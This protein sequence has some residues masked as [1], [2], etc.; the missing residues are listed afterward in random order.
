MLAPPLDFVQH[1][2][3]PQLAKIGPQVEVQLNHYGF[4]PAGKGE[5]TARINRRGA[6]RGLDLIDRDK[7]RSRKVVAIVAAL[8]TSIA[9]RE[10]HRVVRKLNWD[11][12]QTEVVDVQDPV[13]P[14]NVLM[15]ELEYENVT[16]V[17]S[18]FGS[19]NVPAERVADAIVRDIRR[20]VRSEVPVG[21]NLAD[22]LILPMAIAAHFEDANGSFR[23]GKLTQHSITHAE[24]IQKF[25]EVEVRCD[26]VGSEDGECIVSIS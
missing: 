2:Y 3:L 10:I 21:P 4:Y 17:F 18:S 20:Y 5:F 19:V 12:V 15:V 26:Q 11:R 9:D 8:P 22:Q 13:G 24:I 1:S 25:L 6:V 14:G 7:L 16:T 23:T